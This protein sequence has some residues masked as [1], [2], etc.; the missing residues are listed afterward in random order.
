VKSHIWLQLTDDLASGPLPH[1][2]DILRDKSL[3][4]ERITPAVDAVLSNHKVPVWATREYKP[5]AGVWSSDEVAAGLNRVYRLILQE[6]SE[7]P[8]DL[9]RDVSLLPIVQEVHAGRIGS[10]DLP[11][12]TASAMS[13][14]TDRRSRDAICLDEAH[15]YSRGDPRI[16]V[17]VLDT[18]V[19]LSHPEL[20]PDIVPG[21]DFVDIIDGATEFVGDFLGY[22]EVPDDE[23]GHGTHVAG[24]I[25]GRGIKMPEGVASRCRLMPV[26]VLGA[27]KRGDKLYGAGLEDN[28]NPAVK[29]AVDHGAEVINMSLGMPRTGGGLPHRDVVEY[30]RLKGVTIVAA[31]GNDGAEE[32]YYP[33]ALPSVIAV[34]A[35]D[36]EGN[37]AAFSTYGEQVSFLA[38]GTDVYSSHLKNDYAFSSGTSHAAPFVTG[39]VALLKSYARSKGRRLSDGQVKS[40]LKH[41]ADKVGRGFKHRKAGYGRLNLGD[42]MRLLEH[43]LG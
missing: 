4:T 12:P 14:V 39:A 8:P 24:I 35:A 40:I 11:Q 10:V 5:A 2:M 21:F 30:A 27:M 32:L 41:T 9:I 42:A 18:G 22:D 13:A 37:V 33:G 26:R 34:G 7:V 1:W 28:I 25:S 17:A 20:T 6:D 31:S 19:C 23:V 16:T 43:K 3:A 15:R 36:Q 29:Y 38:P